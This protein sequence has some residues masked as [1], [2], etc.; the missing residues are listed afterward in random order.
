MNDPANEVR[1]VP[2]EP[3][4]ELAESRAREAA[5]AEILRAIAA[6]PADVGPVL[7]AIAGSACRYCGAEDAVVLLIRDGELHPLAHHGSVAP[8]G[9]PSSISPLTVSGY[10]VIEGRTIHVPDLFDPSAALYEQAR[11]HARKTGQ[12]AFLAAPMRR[13]DRAIGAILLRK[14]QPIPFSASQVM[15][16]ESFADQAAIAIANVELVNT[17]VR[18]RQ[19][20]SRFISPQVAELI[21]SVAGA[22]L[23]DGHRRPITA[24]FCDLRGFTTFAETA[25]PEE[26]LGLL[27]EYHGAMGELIVAHGGT[28]E[29]FAG[30]AMMTFFNDPLL[31]DRHELHAVRMAC[32]MRERF[33][34]M[35]ERWSKKGYDLGLGIGAAVGYATLGRIGFE[36]RYDYGAV[37][38]VVILASRLASEARAGQILISQRLHSAVDNEV[39]AALIGDLKLKGFSRAIQALD[40]VALKSMP[41]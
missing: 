41:A 27:R 21:T 22:K 36:G 40:L 35:A 18:Q 30:D 32:A 39:D 15:L 26:V 6:S 14:A 1:V 11:A 17:V 29:H 2:S 31:L 4:N 24:V 9:T 34:G 33:A 19:E 3:N 23:L 37:G 25:E 16:V 13:G 12:R 38:N 28:L 5:L 7:E 8:Q 20:L 10:S